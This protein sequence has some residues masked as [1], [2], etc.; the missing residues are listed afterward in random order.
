MRKEYN[1]L[2]RD[3]IPEMIASN[4]YQ[5][6]VI[7]LSDSEYLAALKAKLL[8]EAQEAAKTETIE[9][10]IEEVADIYEVIDALILSLDISQ[11]EI[12][13]KQREKKSDRGGFTQRLYLLW[14]EP[15]NP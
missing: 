10:L 4:G 12:L 13:A 3:K 1:K 7:K 9:E 15:N 2:I 8:E 6:Q 14:S 5:Y 11:K